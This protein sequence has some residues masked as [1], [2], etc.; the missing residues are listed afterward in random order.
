MRLRI[1]LHTFLPRPVGGLL[2]VHKIAPF[3]GRLCAEKGGANLG[4]RRLHRRSPIMAVISLGANLRLP[5]LQRHIFPE[6]DSML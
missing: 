4:R 3:N 1:S 5:F 6:T 2:A